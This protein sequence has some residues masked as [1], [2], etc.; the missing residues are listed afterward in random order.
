MLALYT[1]MIQ[2]QKPSDGLSPEISAVHFKNSPL[3]AVHDPGIVWKH[4][5][6]DRIQLFRPMI[7]GEISLKCNFSTEIGYFRSKMIVFSIST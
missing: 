3:T 1:V 4:N 2:V 5:G 6:K 7:G